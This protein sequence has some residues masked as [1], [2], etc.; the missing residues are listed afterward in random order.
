MVTERIADERARKQRIRK[1]AKHLRS[2][3]TIA[4]RSFWYNV[5]AH[6]FAGYKFRRQ[7]PIGP[8]IVDF[9]CLSAKLVVELDGG[10]HA[11]QRSYDE[12]RDAFLSERGF[13]VLRIWN[14]HLNRLISRLN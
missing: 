10:Q 8:Y 6:R 2:F 11:G 14:S 3:Q 7:H 5:R 4:E 1:I 9:V 13:R 12:K